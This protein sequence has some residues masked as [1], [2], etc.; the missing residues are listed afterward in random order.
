IYIEQCA[1]RLRSPRRPAACQGE[2]AFHRRAQGGF[3]SRRKNGLQNIISLQFDG[4]NMKTRTIG[5]SLALC[6]A[7]GTVCFA[8]PQMGTWQLNEAKS[9]LS[10][11]APK[12]NT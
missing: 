2:I 5:L 6:F 7:A 9:K 12:N 1:R 3:A 8:N 10:P 4:D 11:E